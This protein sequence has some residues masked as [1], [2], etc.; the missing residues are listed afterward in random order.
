MRS[1]AIDFVWGHQYYGENY[2]SEL[3]ERVEGEI[4]NSEMG[5]NFMRICTKVRWSVTN[6][7]I[8]RFI[9]LLIL[10]NCWLVIG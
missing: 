2:D 7:V 9:A 5:V 6:Q 4:T 10:L 8:T 1:C 3:D